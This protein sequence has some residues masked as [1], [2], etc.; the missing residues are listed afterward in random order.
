MSDIYIGHNQAFDN[1]GFGA[2]DLGYGIVFM[3]GRDVMIEHNV[4]HDNGGDNLPPGAPPNGPSGILVYDGDNV[5]IQ[6]NEVYRQRRDPDGPT[7]NARRLPNSPIPEQEG[8]ELLIFGPVKDLEI[9][10]NT[11]FS[12]NPEGETA[13]VARPEAMIGSMKL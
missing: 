8:A 4:V 9:Y 12:R 11:F 6:H 7:D 13:R 1:T 5:T 3:N 10:N 2:A